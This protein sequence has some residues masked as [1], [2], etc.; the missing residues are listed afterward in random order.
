MEERTRALN[1]EART[2]EKYEA[3]SRKFAG[4]RNACSLESM[5]GS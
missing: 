3:R 2:A 5:T 1:S 4:L